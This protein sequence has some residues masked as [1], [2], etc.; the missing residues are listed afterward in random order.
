MGEIR[1]RTLTGDLIIKGYG[2]PTLTLERMWLLQREIKARGLDAIQGNLM[3][4]THYFALPE[5]DAGTFDGE[6]EHQCEEQAH[7]RQAPD[8]AGEHTVHDLVHVLLAALS[9]T[10]DRAIR[11]APCLS[12]QGLDEP[13]MPVLDAQSAVL[14]Y[15]GRESAHAFAPICMPSAGWLMLPSVP[16]SISRWM[17]ASPSSR[18]RATHRAFVRF[19]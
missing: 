3:L 6:P 19:G 15:D 2:D 17:L 5:L 4:D 8:A 16:S 14:S 9:V 11:D 1:N 7:G 18:R 10:R 12:E 13:V